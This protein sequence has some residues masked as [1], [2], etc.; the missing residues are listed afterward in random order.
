MVAIC[1]IFAV[2]SPLARRHFAS[3]RTEGRQQ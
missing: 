1:T 3:F 2:L